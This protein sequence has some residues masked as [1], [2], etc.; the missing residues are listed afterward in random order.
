VAL[1]CKGGRGGKNFQVPKVCFWFGRP[2]QGSTGQTSQEKPSQAKGNFQGQM[3][4]SESGW[5]LAEAVDISL[6][7]RA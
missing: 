4:F 5:C 7:D 1:G 2:K 6:G 3:T